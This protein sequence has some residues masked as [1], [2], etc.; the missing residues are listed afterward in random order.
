MHP[1]R[2]VH[3][4]HV[5][6]YS[7]DCEGRQLTLHT[8]F[9]D[10]DPIEYTDVVFRD[11]FAHRF[12]HVLKGNI[13]FDI[14]EVDLAGLVQDNA[15]LLTVSW[16]YG[17]PPFDYDGDLAKLVSAMQAASARAF[18]I[19]SSY[20]LSGWVVARSSERVGR[21]SPARIS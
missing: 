11:V 8:F 20:G 5:Y 10:R 18:A 3:D 1:E 9:R 7:V 14:Q 13:L 12:E 21:G 17:W 2:S 16:R 4:N 6:A 15:E 19:S